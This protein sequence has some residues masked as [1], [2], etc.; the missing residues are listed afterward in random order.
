ML[1]TC[2]CNHVWNITASV[3]IFTSSSSCALYGSHACCTVTVSLPVELTTVTAFYMVCRHKSFVDCRLFWM[4]LSVWSLVLAS[5]NTSLQFFMTCFTGC[6]YVSRYCLS[7]RCCLLTA[8]VALAEP[9]SKTFCMLVADVAGWAHVQL[10]VT[11]CSFLRLEWTQLSGASMLQLLSFRTHFW[12]ICM[13][14]SSAVDSLDTGWR[15]SLHSGICLILWKHYH[16]KECTTL[17]F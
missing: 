2:K 14:S 11:T 3:A 15:P 9:T 7:G 6:Q 5:T 8:S 13:L 16:F 10:N 17:N 1:V 12:Q 4:V